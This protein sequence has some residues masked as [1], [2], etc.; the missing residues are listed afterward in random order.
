MAR[1]YVPHLL[2]A[3]PQGSFKL[4]GYCH[5]ALACWEIAH[6]LEE[7]GRKVESVVMI[8]AY[9]ILV[10][11]IRSKSGSGGVFNWGEWGRADMDALIDKSGVELDRPKRI[12]MMSEALMI[13]KREHLLIPLHQQPMAW[14]IRGNVTAMVQASDNKPRLWLTQMQ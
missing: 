4:A 13:A 5:G 3:W 7:V 6:Q 2:E 10:Q 12:A 1:T 9:S 11:V 14:A 8:D